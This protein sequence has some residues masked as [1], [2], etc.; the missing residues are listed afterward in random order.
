MGS[1]KLKRRKW[2][3][4]EAIRLELEIN[5]KE[6]KKMIEVIADIFYHHVCQLQKDQTYSKNSIELSSSLKIKGAA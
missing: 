5:K 2:E 4:H 6:Y 1:K 3:V